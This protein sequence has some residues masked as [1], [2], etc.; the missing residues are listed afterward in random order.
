MPPPLK[1]KPEYIYEKVH[2]PKYAD[3]VRYNVGSDGAIHTIPAPN[4]GSKNHAQ[5]PEINYNT[6]NNQLDSDLAK[7]PAVFSL[8]KPVKI[9]N[10]PSN[11]DLIVFFK[12][13]QYQVKENTNDLSIKNQVT[14][15]QFYYAPD[16]DPSL[17][18]HLIHPVDDPLSI[19]TNGV[20]KPSDVHL[21]QQNLEYEASPLVQGPQYALEPFGFP[22][23]S[24]PQLQQYHLQ[25]NAMLKQGMFPSLNPTYLV[26]QSNNLLGQHQSLQSPQ[27]FRPEHGYIDTSVTAQP[28]STYGYSQP[29][30]QVASIGQIYQAQ[31]DHLHHG[32][33]S[34]QTPTTLSNFHHETS[35][36]EENP[37]F[38]QV[39]EPK[40]ANY[41]YSQNQ[42]F[43][44][45]PEEHLNQNDIQNLLY[46]DMYQDYL[47]NRQLQ[48]D[49]V[50]REAQHELYEKQKIAKQQSQTAYDL[51]QL[52]QQEKYNPL[53]IVV[54][55][56]ENQQVN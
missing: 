19:P 38:S 48:N 13:H 14:G 42:N 20:P 15:Q 10:F 23:T 17:K 53:R 22:V 52:V 5:A 36:S 43:I 44:D 51:H 21:Y 33:I 3:P 4:L 37:S 7:F 27:L 34:T 40:P 35:A 1:N 45:L 18:A 9:E 56:E 16:N 32:D 46:N 29:Q 11:F 24:Q 8:E 55:D 26:M 54:P 47:S 39:Y 28:Y 12:G 25:Q 2:V 30:Q 6:L 31:Q 50:L 41:Q 49:L